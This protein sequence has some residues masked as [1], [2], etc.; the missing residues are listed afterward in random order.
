MGD[1]KGAVWRDFCGERMGDG[2]HCVVDVVLFDGVYI[3]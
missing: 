2:E 1:L 3:G